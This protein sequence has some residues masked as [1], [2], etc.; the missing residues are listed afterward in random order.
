MRPNVHCS[1]M[2]YSQM[3]EQPKCPSANEWIKKLWN[4]YTIEYYAAE[5]TKEILSFLKTWMEL[6]T[7]MLSEISQAVR[8][9]Y[10]TIPPIRG[11]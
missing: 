10:Q 8:D 11:I 3:L 2:Y 9:K 7:I 4:I 5:I 1:T 6:E